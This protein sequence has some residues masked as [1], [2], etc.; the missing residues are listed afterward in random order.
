MNKETEQQID[1]QSITIGGAIAYTA[2]LL[3]NNAF[4]LALTAII[5]TYC[6]ERI[7]N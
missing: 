6:I 5:T 1:Y 3:I 7:L 2:E 4:S